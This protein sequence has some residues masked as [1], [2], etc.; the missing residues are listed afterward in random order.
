MAKSRNPVDVSMDVQVQDMLGR[1]RE[2]G[3]ET[4]F[5]R[6]DQMSPRCPFGSAGV[7]CRLCLEGPCRIQPNG[8]GPQRGVCG[9]NADTIVARNF[10]NSLIQGTAA[11]AEHAREVALALLHTAEGKAPYHI[12]D[13]GKLYRIAEGL[14][15]SVEG[16]SVNDVAKNVALAALEDFQRPE[17]TM[18]W[19]AF[20]GQEKSIE[21]WRAL[22]LAPV[23]SHLEIAKSVTRGAMGSDADPINLLLGGIN[24]GIVDGYGGLHLSTDLQDVLFGTPQ[25]VKANYSLGVLDEN[26]INI[27]VHGHIPL[28]S[29]KVVEWA[30]KL[31][32]QAK[33]AGTD[34]I[35][36]VGV[37]CSGNELLMRQ[38][39]SI[40]S[41]FSSQELVI[42]SGALEAMVVDIQ[43][44]M[45]GIQQ[46]AECYH[47]EIIT[48]LGHVKIAGATHVNFEPEHADEAA[49]EIVEKA[50][51]NYA[52][53]DHQ[54]VS[55]PKDSVETYAGFSAEQITDVLSKLNA[56]KPLQ[57]LIDALKDGTI[58]GIAAMVGCTNPREKQDVG[59]V[60]VAK[61]LMKN[62]V[63]VLTTG[64]TAHSLAK[65]GLMN[66]DGV[67]ECGEGVKSVLKLLGEQAGLPSLP[68][69]LHMGSCVD[70]SR[71]ADLL[72]AIADELDI[73]ISDIP[74]VGS[75]PETHNPKA[76][77]IG[78]YFISH[79]V[80]VH[81]G[82]D[83][84]V[85]GSTLV[86]QTLTGNRSDD[87]VTVDRLFGGKLIYDPDP[88]SAAKKLIVRIDMKRQ[89]L[90]LTT[91]Q[92]ATS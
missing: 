92:G 17:G 88:I 19:V 52:N 12:K 70:N 76:L 5:D 16:K 42:V 54:N 33:A 71:P 60:T 11:H 83:P 4:A 38:G 87:E 53:R 72:K 67:K 69:A 9:A 77:S 62:D 37:C 65:N 24:L 45:P 48:T 49:K 23:N 31:D 46:V 51:N 44:I 25:A 56:E 68:P 82:V 50:I 10:M 63:L 81:V 28:L 78:T 41:S 27:A 1:A 55:I 64:C 79:G 6:A 47:T 39:V 57:P 61:E 3:V 40:A 21:K 74:V 59:N 26:K 30:R 73:A 66:P 86:T 90:G 89:L 35:N 29:E 91:K 7:C 58:R 75:C 13:V 80:D 15:I 14:K 43:C 18:N 34:G 85:S 8:K 22:G 20:R 36:I 84:Q 2:Q 32:D